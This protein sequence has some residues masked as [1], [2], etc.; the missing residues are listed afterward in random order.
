MND[1]WMRPAGQSIPLAGSP[2]AAYQAKL[3]AELTAGLI[4]ATC[5][6]PA[7]VTYLCMP[8]R[9]LCCRDCWPETRETAGTREPVCAVCGMPATGSTV[10][11]AVHVLAWALLC[12]ACQT[13]G[14]VPQ[15]VN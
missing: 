6:H 13:T 1:D 15:A 11:L 12:T 7:T 5:P 4:P 2:L 3:T 10:W 8:A 14:N 9:L